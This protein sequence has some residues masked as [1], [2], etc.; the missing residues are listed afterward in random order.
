MEEEQDAALFL[1]YRS[2]DTLVQ[3]IFF[4]KS[5][6]LSQTDTMIFIDEIQE[7]PEALNMLRY[8]YEKYP[9]YSVIAAGSLLES[10][11]I[12]KSN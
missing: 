2:I 4:E 8:F 1:Q 3:A 12:G 7:V 5:M 10:L 6:L 9:Q 11:F